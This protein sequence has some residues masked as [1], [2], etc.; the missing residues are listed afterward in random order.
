MR[1]DQIRKI[2]RLGPARPEVGPQVERHDS[3]RDHQPYSAAEIAIG[4]LGHLTSSRSCRPRESLRS[5]GGPCSHTRR[6]RGWRQWLTP[7]LVSAHPWQTRW[8]SILCV[9]NGEVLAAQHARHQRCHPPGARGGDLPVDQ[10]LAWEGKVDDVA[11]TGCGSRRTIPCDIKPPHESPELT[12]QQANLPCLVDEV[13]PF[14]PQAK[15]GELTRG[16]G[17][18]RAILPPQHAHRSPRSKTTNDDKERDPANVTPRFCT[19]PARPG[20]S[21]QGPG[22]SVRPRRGARPVIALAAKEASVGM[23]A[24]AAIGRQA[25]ARPLV[26]GSFTETGAVGPQRTSAAPSRM[27]VPHPAEPIDVVTARSACAIVLIVRSRLARSASIECSARRSRSACCVRSRATAHQPPNPVQRIK[28]P[29]HSAS[30]SR[31]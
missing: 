30:P 9:P 3:Q 12:D 5:H 26:R 23:A 25:S 15:P 1:C 28:R 4:R 24:A 17:R 6:A 8:P 31:W 7:S 16:H 14:P 18:H 27:Q 22:D 10:I 29:N 20:C 19:S 2:L 13:G 11:E 21:D